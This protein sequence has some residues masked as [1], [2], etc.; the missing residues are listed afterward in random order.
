M[1]GSCTGFTG[2][3]SGGLRC[4]LMGTVPML[5]G[6]ITTAPRCLFP[7]QV[8]YNFNSARP[9]CLGAGFFV[10]V[11]RGTRTGKG[12][13][14]RSCFATLLGYLGPRASTSG[15]RGGGIHMSIGSFF[16]SGPL[17]LSSGIGPKGVRSCISPLFCTPGIS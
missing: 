10:H 2:R 4:S 3:F 1:V 15:K 12:G 7:G 9:K 16:R 17:G 11:V 8:V 6:T 5:S 13:R 14:R